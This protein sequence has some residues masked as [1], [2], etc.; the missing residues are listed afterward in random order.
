[1]VLS[2]SFSV[3]K[4]LNETQAVSVLLE[5][6][7]K[8]E[9]LLFESGAVAELA[10]WE[11]ATIKKDYNK[12]CDAYGCL[13]VLRLSLRQDDSYLY[14]VVVTACR[15][16][17][18][19]KNSEISCVASTEFI[20]LGSHGEVGISEVRKL[21]NSG[22][23]YF[24]LSASEAPLDL[25][26]TYQRQCSASEPDNRFFWNHA[27]HV[28]LQ[29]FDIDCSVWLLNIM[30]GGIELK[31]VYAGAKQAKAM[32]ISRLSCE[33][34]GTRFNVRG[35]ND[36]GHVANFVETEQVI[37]LDDL[38]SSFVQTRGSVPMFWEQPGIQ[39]GSHKVK[40][41]RGF[42]ASSPA[43]EK[44]ISALK[45]LYGDQLLINL[46]GSKEGESYLTKAYQDHLKKSSHSGNTPLILFDY[47][48]L[49]KGGKKDKLEMLKK[50]AQPY[51][52]KFKVFVRKGEE[53]VSQQC[54]TVRVNCLDCLDRTNAVQSFLGLEMLQAQLSHLGLGDKASLVSRFVECFKTMW[55]SNGNLV[56][57]TY[58]GTGAMEGGARFGSKLHDGAVSV[59]RTI[60]NNF[61]DGSKQEA[62]DILLLGNTF[63][64]ELGDRA[65]AL[66]PGSFLHASPAILRELCDR[67]LEYTKWRTLR[68]C[69]GTFNVNGG[70]HFRSIAYKH[71]SLDD[72]LL[73]FHLR[74]PKGC[75]QAN[76]DFNVPTDIFAI[77]FEELVDLKA[78][79]ILSTSAAQRLDWGEELKRVIS[80]DTPYVLL[81]SEQLVGVCLFVFVRSRL[82]N[83]IRD[84]A[85]DSVKTGLGGSAGNKGGVA[86][87]FLLH[88]TSLCF[89]CSHFAAGQSNIADRNN[90]YHDIVNKIE[91]PMGRTVIPH[92]Y[93]FWCG[94][95][96]YRIDLPMED[97]KE[98]ILQENFELLQVEDQLT[99]SKNTNKC[100]RGFTE[101]KLTFAPTYKFDPFS[102]DYD[103][104]EKMRIPAWTDRVLWRRRKPRSKFTASAVDHAVDGGEH[105]TL[106]D[107]DS[108][109]EEEEEEINGEPNQKG[110]PKSF[111]I[112]EDNVNW[113]PGKLLYYHSAQLKTSDHRPVVALIQIDIQSLDKEKEA[114]VHDDVM[115]SMGPADPTVI[116]SS[117]N[118]DEEIN[119]EELLSVLESI[120]N[121]VLVRVIDDK[122]FITFDD[123]RSALKAL[124]LDNTEIDGVQIT[125]RLKSESLLSKTDLTVGDFVP[126]T[127][128]GISRAR[129]LSEILNDSADH[130]SL[131]V[132]Q[133]I[134]IHS[135]DSDDDDVID[136]DVDDDDVSLDDALEKDIEGVNVRK[137]NPPPTRPVRPGPP[138]KPKRQPQIV[139]HKHEL[140]GEPTP[141]KAKPERPKLFSKSP[142]GSP[143]S[144]RK[145]PPSRPGRPASLPAENNLPSTTQEGNPTP[146]ARRR[147][148]ASADVT[149]PSPPQ[150]PGNVRVDSEAKPLP[151][152]RPG[153]LAD[154]NDSR[155]LPPA[156]QKD[157]METQTT[158]EPS[159]AASNHES[160]IV[161]AV[162]PRNHVEKP[163][164]NV[165]K[166]T[167]NTLENKQPLPSLSTGDIVPAKSVSENQTKPVAPA[168]P[169]ANIDKPI[170]PPPRP[171]HPPNRPPPPSKGK[172]A[173]TKDKELQPPRSKEV[174]QV[175]ESEGPSLRQRLGSLKLTRK[176]QRE[177]PPPKSFSISGPFD[178]KHVTHVDINSAQSLLQVGSHEASCEDKSGQSLETHN[179]PSHPNPLGPPVPISRSDSVNTKPVPVPRRKSEKNSGESGLT[180]AQNETVMDKTGSP[181]RVPPRLPPRPPGNV[182]LESESPLPPERLHVLT[183]HKT[184]PELPKRPSS[185]GQNIDATSSNPPAVPAR[186]DLASTDDESFPVAPPRKGRKKIIDQ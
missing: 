57:R 164:K 122:L 71:Q 185:A 172:P 56:S 72:W 81:T 47:H 119:T 29:K 9:S 63:V 135:Q 174:S 68:V 181:E 121:T 2:K 69:V 151:P 28:H 55:A 134:K 183:D 184:P 153:N 26:L 83:D 41:S 4:R 21:L 5:K 131:P 3:Y 156:R 62:I 1:M 141:V 58:T 168:R 116:I 10:P 144:K 111:Y 162:K 165:E 150:R 104:S 85:M 66:L 133:P 87:R 43:F 6:R 109:S 80:R 140:E 115:K 92:D 37:V 27:L 118:D 161:P 8:P 177:E 67:H 169:S 148:T 124:E 96:N 123:G 105:G 114:D 45:G 137:M 147:E 142:A 179:M 22:S 60:R 100:F 102:D 70:Q 75:V 163:V 117:L 112:R 160:K 74:Q 46:L 59:R 158:S 64:G 138:S 53:I 38:V 13:G 152:R 35:V 12:V 65:R 129:S 79:N 120:G 113:S 126:M 145:T 17:G 171:A 159:T 44:H 36:D 30:C 166:H 101:G 7:D 103:T 77:G 32:V 24:T 18:K 90:D 107:I 42:E 180:I 15:S 31:T 98:G 178:V 97:V 175:K 25:S 176:P 39:V 11:T 82:V 73:D 130:S 20:A 186:T 91:F 78:G 51:L 173:V 61:F 76:T 93:V 155:P 149:K 143:S 14:L 88:S 95:F 108:E 19:I 99:K 40:L 128:S 167:D 50:K 89:V 52:E 86:I 157:S 33:R 84:V 154:H 127:A 125:L 16:V 34:A 132:L 182:N 110:R 170:T 146:P 106:V 48:V 94:D 136:D 54:G 49:C 23:F 139:E